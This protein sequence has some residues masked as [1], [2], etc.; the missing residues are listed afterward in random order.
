MAGIVW[1]VTPSKMLEA[2]VSDYATAIKLALM[3]L[4]EAWSPIIEDYMKVNAPWKDRTANA[5][6][7]LN[8]RPREF[9]DSVVID[10]AHGMFYGIY[11]E[12]SNAG[13]YAIIN[14]TLDKYSPLVWKS[15]LDLLK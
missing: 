10:L 11:L 1:D 9:K 13:R 3:E 15:V 4:A 2:L 7:T 8:V 6:Q 12:L 5:R 14:P